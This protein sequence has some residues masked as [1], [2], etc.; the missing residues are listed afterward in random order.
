MHHNTKKTL[1]LHADDIFLLKPRLLLLPLIPKTRF[2]TP[3][4]FVILLRLSLHPQRCLAGRLL[5]SRLPCPLDPPSLLSS[6]VSDMSSSFDLTK[7]TKLN[8]RN[9]CNWRNI[10][11]DI[12]ILRDLWLLIY[13]LERKSGLI[14]I[15]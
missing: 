1:W 11:E 12:L 10:I 2:C 9:Y 3:S 5:L 13:I 14:K 7:V 15:R 8:S 6:T 4:S